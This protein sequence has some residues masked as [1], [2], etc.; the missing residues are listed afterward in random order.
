LAVVAAVLF[1][2]GLS[3]VARSYLRLLL[4]IYGL[5]LSVSPQLVGD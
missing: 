1:H 3:A 4:S 5:L 2:F